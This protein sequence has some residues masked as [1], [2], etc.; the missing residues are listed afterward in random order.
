M[1]QPPRH[2]DRFVTQEPAARRGRLES[3]RQI[4]RKQETRGDQEPSIT[5]Q[6]EQS[7]LQ[8]EEGT[9]V[10]T[11]LSTEPGLQGGRIRTPL[12][13][14][15]LFSEGSPDPTL[16]LHTHTSSSH[17]S[18]RV[19]SLQGTQEALEAG[20]K[21][22]N[23]SKPHNYWKGRTSFRDAWS[24]G[25]KGRGKAEVH[26]WEGGSCSH[27]SAANKQ[28]VFLSTGLGAGCPGSHSAIVLQHGAR[29]HPELEFPPQPARCPVICFTGLQWMAYGWQN[30]VSLQYSLLLLPLLSL[31][32]R[33]S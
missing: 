27:F 6:L 31:M 22:P 19:H 21:G 16:S 11:Q 8:S 15:L 26:S 5:G 3:K 7:S 24:P 33:K 18:D 1:A 13:A 32:E 9:G 25:S 29:Q 17:S 30:G 28:A 23:A 10:L 12:S 4:R 14:L 2:C 20:S